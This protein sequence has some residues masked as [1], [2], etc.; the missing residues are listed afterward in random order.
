MIRPAV[1]AA[2]LL[3]S[4]S[5]FAQ[6]DM[7]KMPGMKMSP[8]HIEV[9]DDAAAHTLTVRMGPW[10]LPAHTDH[11]RA[12]QLTPQMLT[13]PFD[14]WI[15]AYH[16]ALED[17]SGA[18]LPGRLV[19][20]VA[21]W[22]TARSDFLCPAKEEHIFGAGGEMNEWPSLPGIGYRVYKGDRIRIT[23]MFHNPTD[24]SYDAVYL[25]V[26]M[27]YHPV[28]AGKPLLSVYP[29]WFDVKECGD[30]DFAIP[31][32]G[33]TLRGQFKLDY[34]GRLL[35]VGGHLHDYG[36]QLV[37]KKDGAAEPIATLNAKLDEQGR[38]LSMPIQPFLPN[39]VLLSKGEIVDVSA[40]YE[41]PK[42]ADAHGMGIVVGYFL[43]DAD[44]A[45]AALAR[46]SEDKR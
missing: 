15:T 6:H 1:P 38:I 46:K 44:Q 40:T 25:K 14:G 5:L 4:L 24:T 28:A 26:A 27:E 7:S 37:L 32:D 11:M 17:A 9:K 3:F 22:N 42:E 39:G 18:K 33:G 45:M 16:P 21:F 23:T 12:M 35:G 19:H 31:A 43:P 41:A 34:A 10:K 20:H 2:I 13:I 30:S 8:G 29:A 36:E